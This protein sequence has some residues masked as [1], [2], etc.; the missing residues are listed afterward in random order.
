[1]ISDQEIE[2]KDNTVAELLTDERI[3]TLAD[4]AGIA[5]AAMLAGEDDMFAKN[6]A[7]TQK[8]CKAVVAKALTLLANEAP[9]VYDE[10]ST[11]VAEVFKKKTGSQI[12]SLLH[13]FLRMFGRLHN[14]DS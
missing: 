9:E 4:I 2:R 11:A 5:G 10:I 1:M 7:V 14:S 6:P 3:K 13:K 12:A 8:A